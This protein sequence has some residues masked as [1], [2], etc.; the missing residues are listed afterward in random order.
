M[1]GIVK[2]EGNSTKDRELRQLMEDAIENGNYMAIV[3][4]VD[5]KEGKVMHVRVSKNF[6]KR[7]VLPT[8]R[9]WVERAEREKLW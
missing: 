4:R 2:A 5:F 3:A 6:P 7:D 9:H 1:Q 8:L